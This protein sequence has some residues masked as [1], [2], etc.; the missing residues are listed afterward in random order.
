MELN[1]NQ[2]IK[3]LVASVFVLTTS[4]AFASPDYLV[5]HNKTDVESNAYVSGRASNHPTSPHSDGKI[6]WLM[7]RIAC[8]GHT[9]AEGRC[10]AMIKMATNTS[11]PI[12]LGMVSVHVDTGD[13]LP[14]QIRNN[15]YTLTVN[16]PGETT[17]TKD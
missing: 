9:D 15:G 12:E 6:S 7:V 14:K 5:T 17:L 11:H 8:Y 13:I 2:I 10:S 16:G 1:M 3:N 4:T